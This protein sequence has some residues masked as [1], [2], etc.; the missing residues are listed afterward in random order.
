MSSY[1]LY[2]SQCGLTC[3]FSRNATVLSRPHVNRSLSVKP[4]LS[5]GLR[6]GESPSARRSLQHSR[7]TRLMTSPDYP[8]F[9]RDLWRQHPRA[10]FLLGACLPTLGFFHF[11]SDQ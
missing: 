2:R 5:Q 9:I 6:G 1:C 7:V 4:F 8:S 10:G 11:L 3:A